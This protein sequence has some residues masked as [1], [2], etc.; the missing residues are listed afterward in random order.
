MF[1]KYA[2]VSIIRKCVLFAAFVLV[3]SAAA[4]LN[5]QSEKDPHRPGCSDIRCRKIK[6]FLKAHYCG[7]SPFGNGPDDGCE[8]K[9]PIKPRA[10]VDVIAD[11]HCQWNKIKETQECVQKGQ[12]SP[13]INDILMKEL[14]RLGL[15]AK[16]TGKT[17]FWVWKSVKSDWLLAAA[18]YSG[19]IGEELHLCQVIVI[20]GEASQVTV[21]R[22]L[23]FQKT[24]VDVP[25]VTEWYPI[26]LADTGGNS[27]VDVI[28]EGDA[29]ENHWL[30]VVSLQ[31]G[32]PQTIFSGLG[33]Y[34]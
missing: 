31:S 18:D 28:L 34:L 10:G 12:P 20:I 25:E 8:I 14:R 17:H 7:E 24:D 4:R 33:Y 19:S 23:P 22:E 2:K 30:E 15:P 16:A 5:A 3:L 13:A 29:Y 6:S 32:S 27:Q 21:L 26:D 1:M 9:G 11:F